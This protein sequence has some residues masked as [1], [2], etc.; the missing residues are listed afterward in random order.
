MNPLQ[1]FLARMGYWLKQGRRVFGAH[2]IPALL[3]IKDGVTSSVTSFD[4]NLNGE[5]VNVA[6]KIYELKYL[7]EA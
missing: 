6:G 4:L 3:K 5:R 1:P 7:G 2:E